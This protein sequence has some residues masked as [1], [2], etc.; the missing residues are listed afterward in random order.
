MNAKDRERL[1]IEKEECRKALSLPRHT[2]PPKRDFKA[3][4]KKRRMDLS[5]LAAL[6]PDKTLSRQEYMQNL[7][8]QL[9]PD[10]LDYKIEKIIEKLA[11]KGYLKVT[12]GE[13]PTYAWVQAEKYPCE[14]CTRR[15]RNPA[16]LVQH[17]FS[18]HFTNYE[19]ARKRDKP[20]DRSKDKKRGTRA[21]KLKP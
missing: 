19:D 15:F 1:R 18:Y 20:Y 2:T 4:K 7:H 17:Q 10:V 21:G 3:W 11:K 12:K 5:F 14:L 16:K 9:P 13:N 8:Q 6:N